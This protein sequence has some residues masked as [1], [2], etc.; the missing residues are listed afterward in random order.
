[1]APLIPLIAVRMAAHLLIGRSVRPKHTPKGHSLLSPAPPR[2]LR[3]CRVSPRDAVRLFGSRWHASLRPV[4][5]RFD[6]SNSGG[7]ADSV[8]CHLPLR[9]DSSAPAAVMSC[10][11]SR[12]DLVY[13]G[14]MP[15]V[16]AA[17]LGLHQSRSAANGNSST[18][19]LIGSTAQGRA[20]HR[21]HERCHRP[22]KAMPI[23]VH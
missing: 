21:Q 13:S 9:H 10:V 2:Q 3:A 19:Q 15:C 16:R 23:N 7:G 12:H 8:R 17:L 22:R 6:P 14:T 5:L 18:V 11:A 1:M 4:G 20:R